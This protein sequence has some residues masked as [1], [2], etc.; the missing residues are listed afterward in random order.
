MEHRNFHRVKPPAAS[1]FNF[2][3][4]TPDGNPQPR[5][6]PSKEASNASTLALLTKQGDW[7]EE[8]EKRR[9]RVFVSSRR[10]ER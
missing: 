9:L 2:F 3:N 10:R 5:R 7:Q 6:V 1:T 4:T 8:K